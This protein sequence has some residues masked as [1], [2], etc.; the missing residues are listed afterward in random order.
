MASCHAKDAP[1]TAWQFCPNIGVAYFFSIFFGLL[2]IAHSVQAVIYRKFYSIVITISAIL[3]TL[4]FVFRILS[5]NNPASI[6]WYSLWFVIILVAPLFTNAYVYMVMG[7]MVH[8]FHPKRRLFGLKA[9]RFG[10]YFVLLDA[11]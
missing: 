8:N 7:R 2:V 10:F 6:A 3:Q 11:M 5:I 9:R 1:D 4:A